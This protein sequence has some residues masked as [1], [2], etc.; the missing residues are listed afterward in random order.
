MSSGHATDPAAIRARLTHPVVDR[1]AIGWNSDRLSAITSSAS[2]DAAWLTPSTRATDGSCGIST[3][4]AEQRRDARRP[5][6]GWWTFPTTQ[7]ARSRDRDG[8]ASLYERLDEFGLDFSVLY[9]TTGLA[10]PFISDDEMRRAAC[11]AFNHVRRRAVRLSSPIGMTPAAVIPMHTPAE[12]IEELE[13]VAKTLGLKVVLMGSMV[14][15]RSRRLARS[16]LRAARYATWFDVLGLDSEYDYDP[17]WAKC[18]ELRRRADLPYA[19]GAA[20]L[21]RLALELHLQPHRTFCGR[22]RGGVQ[23]AV[24]GWRDAALSHAQV[25]VPRRRRRMGLQ[26]VQRPDRP[27]EK[28]QP[29]GARRS[30]IPPTSTAGV[31]PSCSSIRRAGWAEQLKPDEPEAEGGISRGQPGAGARRLRGVRD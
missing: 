27:L 28:A 1:T 17:V 6:Q 3:I 8:P 12:A 14:S 10:V 22:G 13:Y 19:A 15:R 30:R 4:T 26:S 20:G 9:P 11:R 7:H 18:V 5:Q 29:R 21:S 16:R 24:P 2:L 25:G 31:W 23:G